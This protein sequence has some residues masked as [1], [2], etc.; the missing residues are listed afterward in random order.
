MDQSEI[1]KALDMNSSL[2]DEKKQTIIRPI[3]K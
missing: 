1:L 3:R 2:K